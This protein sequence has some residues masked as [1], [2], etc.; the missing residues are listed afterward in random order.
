M[1]QRI[2]ALA[3]TVLR[4]MQCLDYQEFFGLCLQIRMYVVLGLVEVQFKACSDYQGCI[5][6]IVACMI[7]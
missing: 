6:T 1:A 7:F 2:T 4:F 3:V 5:V